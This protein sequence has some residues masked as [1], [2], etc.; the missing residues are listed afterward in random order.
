MDKVLFSPIGTSDPIRNNY[1]GAMLHIVRHYNPSV[2]Y[3]YLTEE[4]NKK[5]KTDNRYE[6][7]IKRLSPDCSIIKKSTN[8]TNAHDFDEFMYK[9]GEIIDEIKAKYKDSEILI[10][11]SSGTPQMNSALCLE[12]VSN[13]N[14]LIP[15]QVST[16]NEASND[17][18][19]ILGDLVDIDEEFDNLIDQLPEAKNRCIESNILTFKH[20]RIKSQVNSLICGYDYHAAYTILNENKYLFNQDALK[21]AEHLKL[22]FNFETKRAEEVIKT[23]REIDFFPVKNAKP[24]E[25]AE[26]FLIMKIKKE[27]GELTD[28]VLRISPLL[29]YLAEY[30]VTDVL[31]FP[32]Q[33]IIASNYEDIKQVKRDKISCFDK[34]MLDY[35]D[36]QIQSQALNQQK[37]F[38]D[39]SISL[40]NLNLI[41]SYLLE[42]EN[43]LE[44]K[45]K[46]IKEHFL[47]L[48]DVEKEAR[49]TAA[50]VIKPIT[51]ELIKSR[52]QI[53][54]EEITKK[55]EW[56]LKNILE[57]KCKPEQMSDHLNIYKRLNKLLIEEMDKPI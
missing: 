20:M 37:G 35:M 15:I 6:E 12:V 5:D 7:A 14:K 56:L 13:K 36:K 17:S 39:S 34:D 53:S 8:I 22:R 52:C 11:I 48:R 9:F 31:G 49:N 32:L 57:N 26:Y 45:G 25:I 28:F 51:E 43:I 4:M 23:H 38:R 1:D 40:F 50:H 10:N 19:G 44:K 24:K 27:R 29:T 3:L 33:E 42:K 47:K 55:I 54:S 18:K 41:I 2:V 16:P 46:N 30:F 21:I